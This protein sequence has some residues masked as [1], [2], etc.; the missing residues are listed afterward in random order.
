MKKNPKSIEMIR[1]SLALMESL[2][3]VKGVRNIRLNLK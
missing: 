1:Y 2:V 3:E